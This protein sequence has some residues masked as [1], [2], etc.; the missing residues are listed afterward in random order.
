MTLSIFSQFEY[1]QNYLL[2]DFLSKYNQLQ[3]KACNL[4]SCHN[5]FKY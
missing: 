4:G 2:K 3:S 1:P 5:I